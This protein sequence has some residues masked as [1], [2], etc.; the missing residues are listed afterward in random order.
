MAK[1]DTGSMV[2]AY[3]ERLRK[4]AE[5]NAKRTA[6]EDA[7]KAREASGGRA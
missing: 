3:N 5:R 7:A 4:E 6:K 2:D 1:E